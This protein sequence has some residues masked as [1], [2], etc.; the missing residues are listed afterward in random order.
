MSSTR[1]TQRNSPLVTVKLDSLLHIIDKIKDKWIDPSH[2]DPEYIRLQI[3]VEAAREFVNVEV[4]KLGLPAVD[5]NDGL[6]FAREEIDVVTRYFQSMS[7]RTGPR[8]LK[9]NL[10]SKLV[11]CSPDFQH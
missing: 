7:D 4:S 1:T 2:E 3:W 10:P 9:Y 5:S 8:S 11:S 6:V